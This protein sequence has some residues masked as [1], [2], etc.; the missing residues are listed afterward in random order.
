M[1]ATQGKVFLNDSILS[2]V[3]ALALWFL[4]MAVF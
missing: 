1:V 2:A 4:A 3:V